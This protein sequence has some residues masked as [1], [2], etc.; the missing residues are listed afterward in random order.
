MIDLYMYIR[1][2]ADLWIYC[3]NTR[4]SM[5][6]RHFQAV[7]ARVW[8]ILV[9]FSPMASVHR[10]CVL[11]IGIMVTAKASNR[12]N[13]L[14]LDPADGKQQTTRVFSV[15]IQWLVVQ[16]VSCFGSC[17]RRSAAQGLPGSLITRGGSHKPASVPGKM[18]PRCFPER[19][20]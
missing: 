9:A 16:C 6:L 7:V 15:K 11:E 17:R 20:T 4:Y 18:V 5:F 13:R 8:T 12:L 14:F 3:G 10:S 1:I 19:S 2:M